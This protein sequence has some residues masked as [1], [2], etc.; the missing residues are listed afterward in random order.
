MLNRYCRDE[1]I[2]KAFD[3]VQV[4]NLK[5]HD[6]PDGTVLP[7][8]FTI[9]WMQDILDFWYAMV[10]F[11]TTV[12]KTGLNA[13]AN[14]G[15]ITLPDDFILDVRNGYITRL[16][17]DNPN[18]MQRRHR[19]PFQKFLRRQLFFQGTTS[20]NYPYFYCVLGHVLHITPIPTIDT[21]GDIWYYQMPAV[22][23]ANDKPVV[24]SDYV[25]IEYLKI[26]MLEWVGK[27]EV[28]TAQKFCD[29]ILGGMKAAGLLNEPED[30][31][32]PFD[33]MTYT[34]HG[35]RGQPSTWM[36]PV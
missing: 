6:A 18:S 33:E 20:C 12:T 29:K 13:T 23:E 25:L 17:P 27:Y 30:D 15:T 4:P 35:G 28:G 14:T 21:L 7:E 36:G 19:L 9:G 31:E 16:V 34:N 26:R 2:L 3:Q 1:L 24:A 5:V 32:I 11:S 8:A 22:L 10:P